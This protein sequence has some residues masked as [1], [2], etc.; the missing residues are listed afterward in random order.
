MSLSFFLS[1][2]YFLPLLSSFIA[3]FH[4]LAI[5]QDSVYGNPKNFPFNSLNCLYCCT[6]FQN[7]QCWIKSYWYRHQGKLTSQLSYKC[8]MSTV[9]ANY[10]NQVSKSESESEV[11][12]KL[13]LVCN[14]K[15]SKC[16]TSLLKIHVASYMLFDLN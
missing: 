12:N 16:V 6:I 13:R 5:I 14:C 8:A 7:L 4:F 1:L 3:A 2:T 10:I 15:E 11:C 9:V